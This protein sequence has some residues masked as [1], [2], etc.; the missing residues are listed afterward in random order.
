MRSLIIPL[1]AFCLASA[2]SGPAVAAGSQEPDPEPAAS[3]GPAPRAGRILGWFR[4]LRSKADTTS[5][6]PALTPETS[7]Y[8]AP[9]GLRPRGTD[10]GRDAASPAA[11]ST[12]G[13][14]SARDA[15]S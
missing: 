4:K 13:A 2:P 12:P 10:V 14:L 7:P 11:P 1:I 3:A 5:E 9:P 6:V 8:F 15:S